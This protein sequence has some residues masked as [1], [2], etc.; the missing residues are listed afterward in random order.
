MTGHGQP[1]YGPAMPDEAVDSS[2]RRVLGLRLRVWLIAG[3]VLLIGLAIA[4]VMWAIVMRS[5]ID[6]GWNGWPGVLGLATLVGILATAI[7]TLFLA[8]STRDSVDLQRREFEATRL[9]ARPLLEVHASWVSPGYFGVAI[10]WVR[11][12]EPAFDVQVWLK[13]DGGVRWLPRG[14]LPAGTDVSDTVV[15]DMTA[16][17][18]L[19]PFPETAI[20]VP[21]DQRTSGR[22]SPGAPLTIIVAATCF[23]ATQEELMPSRSTTCWCAVASSRRRLSQWPSQGTWP[24]GSR[25]PILTRV[26]IHPR[27]PHWPAKDGRS[28]TTRAGSD[29]CDRCRCSLTRRVRWALAQGTN[30]RR[31]NGDATDGWTRMQSCTGP[32]T[33][34]R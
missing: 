18:S 2:Q 7:G 4:A 34:S 19:W 15:G 11:G 9:A 16:E 24:L 23:A 26:T 31:T 14:T 22:A 17:D 6:W 13:Y 10:T 27:L 3:V 8:V 28:A 29:R 12:T 32:P 5:K 30:R 20:D 21:L 1:G 25:N 33:N